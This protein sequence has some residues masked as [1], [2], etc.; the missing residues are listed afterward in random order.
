LPFPAFYLN[1]YTKNTFPFLQKIAHCVELPFLLMKWRIWCVGAAFPAQA[2][3]QSLW[4]RSYMLNRASDTQHGSHSMGVAHR[5]WMSP[6]QG[7]RMQSCFSVCSFLIQ[8]FLFLI[9]YFLFLISYLLFLISYFSF[10]ISHFLFTNRPVLPI[11][12]LRSPASQQYVIPGL[13]PTLYKYG[14]AILLEIALE[15]G[16]LIRWALP[17]ACGCRPYRAGGRNPVSPIAYS[18]FKISYFLFTHALQSP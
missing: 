6:L 5:L 14:M 2:A 11:H 10:L 13:P 15:V 17:I 9:Y 7:L 16:A 8:N 1:P 3:L 18:L 12:A 4:F